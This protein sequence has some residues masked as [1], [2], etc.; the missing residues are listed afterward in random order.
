MGKWLARVREH[1]SCLESAPIRTFR[2]LLVLEIDRCAWKLVGP[3]G[4]AGLLRVVQ[5]RGILRWAA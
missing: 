4:D 3:K 1:A 5:V 2:G